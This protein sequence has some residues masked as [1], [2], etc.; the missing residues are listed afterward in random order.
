MSDRAHNI[1]SALASEDA[2]RLNHLIVAV[3]VRL[4]KELSLSEGNSVGGQR[5][6]WRVGIERTIGRIQGRANHAH[7]NRGSH[8]N[9]LLI[10]SDPP[11]PGRVWGPRGAV[12]EARD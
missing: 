7:D 9:L 2:T 8:S 10:Y 11:A 4:A 6:V 3:G 5:V 12:L 1:R